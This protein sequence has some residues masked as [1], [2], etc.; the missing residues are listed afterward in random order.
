MKRLLYINKD[1]RGVN[2]MSIKQTEETQ[3]STHELLQS[4]FK[5][6]MVATYV[7]EEK[8]IL[9]ERLGEEGLKAA[10]KKAIK[11][12][13][14]EIKDIPFLFRKLPD[15]VQQ[16]INDKGRKV[17][18]AK[19]K[20]LREEVKDVTTAELD[21]SLTGKEEEEAKSEIIESLMMLDGKG[22]EWAEYV[23]DS[24][25]A[26]LPEEE[27]GFSDVETMTEDERTAPGETAEIR[28]NN[29]LELRKETIRAE[30]R[31][32]RDRRI[33]ELS[34]ISL[35]DLQRQLINSNV[36]MAAM[37]EG[38]KFQEDESIA[39]SVRDPQSKKQVFATG[40][41]FSAFDNDDLKM[42]LNRKY[43]EVQIIRTKLDVDKVAKSGPF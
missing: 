20:E 21:K 37:I 17:Y 29:L 32:E 28:R 27:S 6:E 15:H 4:L 3:R 16:E 31:E 9:Q 7:P 35:G 24:E 36:N 26:I 18:L 33:N 41:A 23:D 42:F 10:E 38:M 34:A 40:E 11:A 2:K 1:R 30:R 14:A 12:R 19:L 43:Q 13:L 25:V 39:W 22:K 5:P 8:R